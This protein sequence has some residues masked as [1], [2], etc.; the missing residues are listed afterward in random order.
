VSLVP[1]AWRRLASR[2]LREWYLWQAHPAQQVGVAGVG[3]DVVECWSNPE[4]DQQADALLIS[5]FEKLKR[6]VFLAQ[7][8]VG[9]RQRHDWH[10]I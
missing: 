3:A 1:T 2:W 5:L 9:V 10:G 4:E 8:A 7:N 6:L